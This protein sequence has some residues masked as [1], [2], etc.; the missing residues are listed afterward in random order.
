M[1]INYAKKMKKLL[2]LLLILPFC[3]YAETV[4][5]SVDEQGNVI[6]TDKPS[7]GAEAIEIKKAQSVKL[8]DI[9]PASDK[10]SSGEKQKKGQKRI[11][12]ITSPKNDETIH[13]N[14]GSVTVTANVDPE[15]KENEQ[16]AL[17]MDGKKVLSGKSSQFFLNYVDRGTHKLA[18]AIVSAEG[19]EISRSDTIE[20]HLRRTSK[21]ED[22]GDSKEVTPLNPPGPDKPD[23]SPTNPPKYEPPTPPAPAPAP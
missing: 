14:E 7:E 3:L 21:L 11:L 12:A 16:L 5:K 1:I 18:V 19:K 8:P 2:F 22:T 23:V 20:F 9:P 4:Y 6:F 15:L 10:T 17:Y 13:H